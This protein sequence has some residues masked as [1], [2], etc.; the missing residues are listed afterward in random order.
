VRWKNYLII[1]IWF[2]L[3]TV[4]KLSQDGPQVKKLHFYVSDD[5]G[6]MDCFCPRLYDRP[7][8]SLFQYTR[9]QIK[10]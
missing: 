10:R 4:E 2:V 7:D 3:E 8:V 5:F 6:S 9:G 1:G